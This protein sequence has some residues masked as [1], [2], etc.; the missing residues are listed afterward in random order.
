MEEKSPSLLN[1][2]RPRIGRLT[3]ESTEMADFDAETLPLAHITADKLSQYEVVWWHHQ[4]ALDESTRA[5][6]DDVA[7]ALLDYVADGGGLLLSHGAVTAASALGIESHEPDAVEPIVAEETGFLLRRAYADHPV[8]DGFETL[9]PESAP[10]GDAVTVHYESRHP[11]DADVLAAR[12]TDGEDEPARKSVLRWS[13]DDGHV[14]GVGHGL[15]TITTDVQQTLL[16]NCLVYAAG[17]AEDPPTVGR[18]KG[19]AEFEALREAVPDANHRPAY[20]FTPPANWLNDPNGLVQWDGMY[21]LFYQYNPAGPFHDTIHW[22]HA[23]SKDLVNWT[24]EPIALEP[25]PHGPDSVGVWS[26]CFVDDGGTPTVMY[27][28]G[29]GTNQL[30]CLAQATDD[31]LRNWRKS[32]ENPLLES[33]PEEID[34]LH[35]IDWHGEFRDHCVWQEGETWYQLIGSGLDGEG[36]AALLFESSDLVEWEYCHPLLTGDWRKTGPV[37]ECPELLQFE[38]G[39]LL[40]VSD[41]SK[42]AYF[43]GEY[44]TDAHRLRPSDNGVLDH[45]VFYAP[46]SF[47]DDAG[48]TLMFGW[49]KE[50]RDPQAQWDAGW[51]GAMSLPRVVSLTE[52]GTPEFSLPSELETLRETHHSFSNRTIA[53]EEPNPLA[54]IEGDTL[55]VKIT[56]N[57]EDVG[58]LGIVLR[59]TPDG[60]ERT[61]VRCD[62][63]H[64]SLIVDRSQSSRSDLVDD[65]P[66]SMPI[67]LED[68]GTLSLHLFLDRSVIEVFTNDAQALA[69]RIYPTR[70]DSTEI[71]L[72]TADRNMTVESLD[73]WELTAE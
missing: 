12:R 23:V 28:G 67:T 72:Y 65:S 49:L 21:H 18:P 26:G 16:D 38:E 41:Y 1:D 55:E 39:A 63:R 52:D 69:T 17:N 24:D 2:E 22:G 50:D 58:E 33:I 34:V 35:S 62:I 44:D 56:V 14:V 71:S 37:W 13:V 73:V 7:D 61:V 70:E 40:H 19:R 43:T 3:T 42:V 68:D 4:S 59:E 60:E 45:G 27:T 20:H 31:S 5:S 64:R 30:P 9:R 15:D 66:E 57:A 8:F 32:D 48:R 10:A 29:A 54:D 46:Q 47:E 6:L 53:P 11:H 36:G 25:D 51:S